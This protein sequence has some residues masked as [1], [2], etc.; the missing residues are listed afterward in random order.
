MPVDAGTRV[1]PYEI[2]GWLGSGGMGDVYRARDPRLGRD[3][4]IKLINDR[5]ASDR[6]RLR[7]FQQEAR[8]AGQ[9]NHPGIVAVYDVG[10]YQ[11]TPYIVSELLEGE[12]LR[13]RLRGGPIGPRRAIDLARQ[14]ALGL[15]AAHAKGIVHRDVKPEN[16]FLTSD[17]R[18][19]I[20]DFGVAKLTSTDDDRAPGSPTET[21]PDPARSTSPRPCPRGTRPAVP[22]VPP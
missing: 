13:H 20:L 11:D 12:T 4:A 8:A 10:T 15:A 21:A 18:I 2:V 3:V 17:G 7:R 22:A 5:L 16:L 9:L 6:D 14:I 19:K 1:G